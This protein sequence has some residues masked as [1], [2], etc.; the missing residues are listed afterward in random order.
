MRIQHNLTSTRHKNVSS[1]GTELFHF[2]WIFWRVWGEGGGGVGQR[3]RVHCRNNERQ[4]C[5][6]WTELSRRIRYK[7]SKTRPLYSANPTQKLGRY[8]TSSPSYLGH[9]TSFFLHISK[10]ILILIYSLSFERKKKKNKLL[11]NRTLFA[12][13]CE[14]SLKLSCRFFRPL[15]IRV[16]LS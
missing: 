5:Q 12:S 15:T 1:S 2:L 16:G 14:C 6:L 8:R 11:K 7:N 9:I 10:K 4:C 3:E 13:F